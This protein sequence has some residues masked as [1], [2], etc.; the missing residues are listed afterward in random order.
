LCDQAKRWAEKSLPRA[1]PDKTGSKSRSVF[2]CAGVEWSAR[3]RELLRL[4][5]SGVR[6]I[7]NGANLAIFG[8]DANKKVRCSKKFLEMR[9]FRIFGVRVCLLEIPFFS[10]NLPVSS[11]RPSCPKCVILAKK[12]P[13]FISSS[14]L[15]ITLKSINRIH[16]QI[17]TKCFGS[18][19]T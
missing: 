14:Y 2:F 12:R 4:A 10:R 18:V 6:V 13:Y 9:F 17:V 15:F 3:S 16:Y 1:V 8:L 5:G 11:L 7:E 19:G